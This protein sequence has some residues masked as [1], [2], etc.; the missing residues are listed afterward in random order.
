MTT[1][2]GEPTPSVT[3][4]TLTD[5]ATQGIWRGASLD[6]NPSVLAVARALLAAVQGTGPDAALPEELRELA[7]GV[8]QRAEVT[9]P[10]IATAG[11]VSLSA[12]SI[13]QSG[14]ESRPVVIVPAGWNPYGWL[15]FVFGYLSL[16]ARGY[17]V[18]AYTPRGI[19][20]PGLVSTSEGF[21]DVA[22][23]VDWADGSRVID[24]AEE[25]LAPSKV[26]FLGLS[27]GSGIS[28]LVAAHDRR[29]R[30]AA[31]AA[32]STWGNLATSLYDHGTRHVE[33]VRLLIGFTGGEEHEKFDEPTRQ[34]LQYFR[35]GQ[36][37]DRVVEW[38]TERSPET[39][40]GITNER[41]IPTYYSN[42]WHEGLFPV[43][44]AIDT[45]EKLTVPK[46]LNLWIGDHGA[47]EGTGI[48]G[49]PTG[50]PFPGLLTPIR[51]AYAW[52]DHHLL[53]EADEVPAW[54]VVNSQVMFT[55]K[56]APVV[57]G[58]RLIT[59]P[60]R[61]EPLDSW[62]DATVSSEAWY[63]GGNGGNGDGTLSDKP[64]KGWSRSFT[65]G[66]ET[67]ATAM[68]EI[69]ATGQKEWF[70]NPKEYRPAAFE[71]N[72]LLL[73]STEALAGGR[74]IRGSAGIRL[75]VSVEAGDAATLVAYLFDVAPDGSARIITHEPFTATGLTAGTERTLDWKLQ[76]A[77]YDLPDGHRLALVVNSRDKLYAFT[78][79]PDSTTT[80]TSPAQG[81]A[82]LELPLG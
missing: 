74:R 34:I 49:V 10:R 12:F 30:V 48:S 65:A 41:R 5:I 13:K 44:E 42:T 40:V 59:T 52:L 20:T 39:Y 8:R 46:H 51:E 60:A 57:G 80:I 26:G 50:L 27:Y 4:A 82:V 81:E 14:S 29:K 16:A 55:Y 70:G 3:D 62:A 7:A 33:A 38:G 66:H 17:H 19:G 37:L 32:L 43:G 71:R 6:I 1:A 21:I 78:G 53:R 23:P 64:S 31:V 18:L 28:Q 61:R 73:W 25:H 67:A 45:F 76:P 63:L 68:D 54:P 79:V 9:L 47:P 24:Y 56:T 35:D 11:G 75:A 15:P 69:M 2:G 77:A 72:R 36:N 22:G 58:G